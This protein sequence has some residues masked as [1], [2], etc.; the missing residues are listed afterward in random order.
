MSLAALRCLLVQAPVK[1][2]GANREDP[3][4]HGVPDRVVEVRNGAIRHDLLLAKHLSRAEAA[5]RGKAHRVY[6]PR[7]VLLLVVNDYL[8]FRKIP[9]YQ[10]LH[11][12]GTQ[13]WLFLSLF[14]PSRAV[15]R[16]RLPTGSIKHRL[17]G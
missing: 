16:Q 6:G 7:H 9:D 17:S 3:G 11:I 10:A 5:V 4:R 15:G 12:R 1:P 13:R 8:V 2:Y 14:P